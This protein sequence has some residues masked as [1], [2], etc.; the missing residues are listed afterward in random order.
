[1][2]KEESHSQTTFFLQ[3]FYSLPQTV[4]VG[5]SM[6][7]CC[8]LLVAPVAVVAVHLHFGGNEA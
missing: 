1:M 8:W 6:L 5:D 4:D 3:L 7:L 2:K